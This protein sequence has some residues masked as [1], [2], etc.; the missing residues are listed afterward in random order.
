MLTISPRNPSIPRSLIM[1]L[2]S[3]PKIT[4]G[5]N[6]ESPGFNQIVLLQR[7]LLHLDLTYE[8]FC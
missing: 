8:R 4:L 3:V 1:I 7:T 6:L 5:V 2:V